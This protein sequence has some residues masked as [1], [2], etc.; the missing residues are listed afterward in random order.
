M[1]KTKILITGR[2]TTVRGLP[3]LVEIQNETPSSRNTSD[4]NKT[5]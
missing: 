1:I 5:P 2:R 3:E 4:W